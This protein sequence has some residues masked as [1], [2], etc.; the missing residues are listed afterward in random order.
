MLMK[1][2]RRNQPLCACGS[3]YS[4]FHAKP[5]TPGK[6]FNDASR[7]DG[8][9]LTYMNIRKMHFIFAISLKDIIKYITACYRNLWRFKMFPAR[10]G[11]A[12]L[13][14]YAFTG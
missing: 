6:D 3:G 12:Q 11:S 4:A 10:A 7:F 1:V 9:I 13:A 14:R 8:A 5:H 2:L